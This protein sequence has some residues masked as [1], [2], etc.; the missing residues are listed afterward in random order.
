MTR[1]CPTDDDRADIP[2]KER[3]NI[4]ILPYNEDKERSMAKARARMPEHISD[5][6]FCREIPDF[7]NIP[8]DV[9][10]ISRF[11]VI[12]KELAEIQRWIKAC[13][14][15]NLI[16]GPR[17]ESILSGHLRALTHKFLTA[18]ENHGT[19]RLKE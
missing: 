1:R 11:R 7:P 18:P 12:H 9:A 17:G 13:A 19:D 4:F 2:T 5:L 10:A 15:G 3:P 14:F 8:D 16:G 6:L